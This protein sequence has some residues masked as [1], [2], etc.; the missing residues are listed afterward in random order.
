MNNSYFENFAEFYSLTRILDGRQRADLLKSLPADE[1]ERLA[2]ARKSEGWDD[3]FVQ[4]EVDA[5]IDSVNKDFGEDLIL[6]RIKVMG[7]A[8][9]PIRRAFWQYITDIFSDFPQI[10]TRLVF[11]G[12]R[13][14]DKGDSPNV[15]LVSKWRNN[16]RQKN[17]G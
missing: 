6:M 12:I 15:F 3:L 2:K 11:G 7:G 14:V 5:L 8:A 16:G 17:K 9:V 13:V 1:R 10:H 4:N